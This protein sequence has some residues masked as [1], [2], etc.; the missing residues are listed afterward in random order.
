MLHSPLKNK[1]KDEE[2]TL[3]I[4]KMKQHK[5]LVHIYSCGNYVC[6]ISLLLLTP[7]PSFLF[8]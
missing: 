2:F 3:F 1:H 8:E 7:F 4:G 5:R 6:P